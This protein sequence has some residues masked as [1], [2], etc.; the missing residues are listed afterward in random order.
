MHSTT[1]IITGTYTAES[2][3]G[4]SGWS[5]HKVS[6]IKHFRS[7]TGASLKDAKEA[8]EKIHDTSDGLELTLVSGAVSVADQIRGF[9]EAGYKVVEKNNPNSPR[10]LLRRAAITEIERGR[11]SEA[12]NILH[13]LISNEG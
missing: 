2:Y 8:V 1:V 9:E 6:A 12:R 13:A 10:E 11:F 3:T 4:R 5:Y 7:M